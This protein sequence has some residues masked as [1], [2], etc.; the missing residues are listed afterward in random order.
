[1]FVYLLLRSWIGMA[2]T[3]IR[4][5]DVAS[6]SLGVRSRRIEYR[7]FVLAA[8]LCTMIGGLISLQ[9]LR[10]APDTAFRVRT[11]CCA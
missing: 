6:A 2:L 1:M 3:A 11:H 4:D 10:V 8:G 5:S 9:K 7:V